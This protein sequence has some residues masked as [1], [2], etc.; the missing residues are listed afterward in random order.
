MELINRAQYNRG[1]EL[2]MKFEGFTGTTNII[3]YD[4]SAYQRTALVTNALI[5]NDLTRGNVLSLTNVDYLTVSGYT[6]VTG[7]SPRS[8]SAW[9]KTNSTDGSIIEWGSNADTG[10]RW[11]VRVVG[12]K[13]RLVCQGAWVLG[14]TD[15]TDDVWHHVAVVAPDNDLT[16]VLI[17]I[18]GTL[19]ATTTSTEV[20]INTDDTMAV[21]IGD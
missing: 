18:D 8:V 7:T 21:V 17:Y 15:I 20:I 9:V 13:I 2:N 1:V 3:A 16:N 10:T 12:G 6:G 11:W 5:S 14:T 4:D 19:D